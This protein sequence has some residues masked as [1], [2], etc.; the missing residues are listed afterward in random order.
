[1][2]GNIFS[3]IFCS[4]GLAHDLSAERFGERLRLTGELR[5]RDLAIFIILKINYNFLFL[6]LYVFTR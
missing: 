2:A 1:M 3:I 4:H 6:L 5:L